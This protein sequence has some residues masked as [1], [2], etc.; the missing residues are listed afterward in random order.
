MIINSSSLSIHTLL[1][2]APAATVIIPTVDLL[3][4]YRY[5][6]Y[7]HIMHACVCMGSCTY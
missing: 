2:V 5:A 3:C 6:Q 7:V 4:A 1:N